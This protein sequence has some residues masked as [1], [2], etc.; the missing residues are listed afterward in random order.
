MIQQYTVCAFS[1]RETSDLIVHA[2]GACGIDGSAF[3]G[4]LQWDSHRDCFSYAV[5]QVGDRAGNGSVTQACIVPLDIDGKTTEIVAS[6]RHSGGSHTVADKYHA[7]FAEK[8][9][10]SLHHGFVYMD[11]VTD[12][13]RHDGWCHVSG[14]D[15][16]RCAVRQ[17]WHGIV[18]VGQVICTAGNGGTCGVIITAGVT[19]GHMHLLGSLLDKI[20]CAGNFRSHCDQFDQSVGSG[21]QVV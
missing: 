6:V 11:T 15:W 13:L 14:T 10:Q 8:G 5:H 18:G 21:K 16:S 2:D 17:R 12:N 4:G 20:Q 1:D 9:K 19:D 3:D 7:V